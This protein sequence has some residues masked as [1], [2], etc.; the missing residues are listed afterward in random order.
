MILLIIVASGK[1]NYS[2]ASKIM[3]DSYED[4]SMMIIDS[5]DY[6]FNNFMYDLESEI[7][8]LEI[9]NVLKVPTNEKEADELIHELHEI[10]SSN[11]KNSIY[12]FWNRRWK[13]VCSASKESS[14]EL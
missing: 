2:K 1:I 13:N 10:T 4:R 3:H 14:R 12:V 5:V 8:R 9:S 11:K 7:L 6:I